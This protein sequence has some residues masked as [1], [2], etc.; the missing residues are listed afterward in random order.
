MSYQKL[1]T[2]D[3][4]QVSPSD[5]SSLE[6]QGARTRGCILYIGTGGDLSVVTSSGAE[7]T[8]T[9]VQDGT[10]LPVQVTSVLSTGTTASNILAL[11]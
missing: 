2:R 4:I 6:E 9:S 1:Q 11:W 3:G 10:F 8:F 7:L 5:T